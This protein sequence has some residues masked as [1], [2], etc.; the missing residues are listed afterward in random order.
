MESYWSDNGKPS[1]SVKLKRKDNADLIV[2][3]MVE[4]KGKAAGSMGMVLLE[5]SCGTIK[6]G[7]GS[8]FSDEQRK[9]YWENDP[10][11]S[12]FETYY[13]SITCDKKTGQ[14]S[15]FLPI[16]KCERFDKDIADSHQEI[17]D[18]V[19]IKTK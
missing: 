5:S 4:G 12:I 7:C 6:V 18:K 8:G 14:K 10:T 2:V 16:F 3:G 11:G 9:Y 19:V 13:D 15:L 17:L 1:C